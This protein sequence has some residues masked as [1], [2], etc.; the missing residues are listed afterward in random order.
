MVALDKLRLPDNGEPD[1]KAWIEFVDKVKHPQTQVNIASGGQVHRTAR[2]PTSRS[3]ESFIHAGAANHTKVKLQYVNS[4]KDHRGEHRRAAEGH[5][6]HS[7]GARGSGTGASRAKSKPVA[8]R[9]RTENPVLRDLPRHAVLRDRVRP[10]TCSGYADANSTEMA[11]TSHPV[12]DLMEEQKGVTE[13]G[14]TRCGWEATRA[15][16][17]KGIE[18]L[19][20]IRPQAEHRRAP[21]PPLRVQQRLPGRVRPGRP[22]NRSASIRTRT[23]SRAVELEDHPWFIGVQYHPEY[24]STALHPHPLFVSFVKGCRPSTAKDNNGCK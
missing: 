8:L 24:K 20:G 10:S 14:G 9:P 1:L 23:W 3:S 6:R 12:I 13:K 19:C 4:E 21:S 11:S 15:P 17:E 5:V 16:C 18:G 22:R 7:G 2:T